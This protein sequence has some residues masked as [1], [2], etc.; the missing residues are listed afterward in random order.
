MMFTQLF[1]RGI[2]VAALVLG[3]S[4]AH[5]QPAAAPRARMLPSERTGPAATAHSIPW[6]NDQVSDSVYR[7]A[8]ERLNRG[9]YKQAADLFLSVAQRVGAKPLAGDALY[10]RAYALY[11]DGG[12]TSLTSALARSTGC[13]ATF[14]GGVDRRRQRAAHARLRR[15]GL[16]RR[17]AVRRAVAESAAGRAASAASASAS[18]V[19]RARSESR[20]LPRARAVSTGAGLSAG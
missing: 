17:C 11:R 12:A 9:Q 19:A 1:V 15:A 7:L 6:S 8:R 2:A 5:A 4:A 16:S 3:P 20:P 14:L 13:R 10:W 18:S